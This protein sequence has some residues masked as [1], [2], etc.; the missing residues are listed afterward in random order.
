MGG[1]EVEKER[2]GRW[3]K[4]C[5]GEREVEKEGMREGGEEERGRKGR[6]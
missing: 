2:R 5:E 3:E 1:R 6:R 4:G